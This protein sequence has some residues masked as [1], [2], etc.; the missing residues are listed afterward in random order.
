VTGNQSRLKRR[1]NKKSGAAKIPLRVKQAFHRWDSLSALV[2]INQPNSNEGLSFLVMKR[3]ISEFHLILARSLSI[4]VMSGLLFS[5]IGLDMG[6]AQKPSS[7]DSSMGDPALDR[8][9]AQSLDDPAPQIRLTPPSVQNST[10]PQVDNKPKPILPKQQALEPQPIPSPVKPAVKWE[11]LVD[12]RP[13]PSHLQPKQPAKVP[14]LVKQPETQ[15]EPDKQAEARQLTDAY[16]ALL[17]QWQQAKGNQ[18]LEPVLNKGQ[19]AAVAIL[20]VAETLSEEEFNALGKRMPGYLLIRSDILVVGPDP[21]F[22]VTLA[23]QKGKPVDVAFFKLV[24]ETLNGY[25]PS[26]MEQL[27][28]LSGCTRF[29]T[30]QLSDL[31]GG[32]TKFRQQYPRAYQKAL[33]DPN[34]L[35]IHDLED[36]LLNSTSACEGPESV[37]QELD[38]FVM[39]H[40]GS[41]LTP[42]LKK[43]L[44]A[45]RQNKA[46]MMFNQGV[47]HLLKEQP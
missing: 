46:D 1:L 20:K 32:W 12:T 34:L 26:T 33:Q 31:Y 7:A 40:P 4:V 42:V 39:A 29:G 23:T 45:L 22:F 38:K 35:L 27:D 47:R 8:L 43:R 36:Q 24:S 25:W 17:I 14:Q 41:P 37:V 13:I 11:P 10:P 30:G 6:W 9:W 3:L 5:G 21:N 2:K 19:E 28:H 16:V 44:Q 18:S 15:G